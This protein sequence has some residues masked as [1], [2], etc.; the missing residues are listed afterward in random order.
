MQ[1]PQTV[2]LTDLVSKKG[3]VLLSWGTCLQCSCSRSCCVQACKHLSYISSSVPGFELELGRL[4]EDGGHTCT[5]RQ[6]LCNPGEQN[7]GILPRGHCAS[8]RFL[9]IC[10]QSSAVIC[11]RCFPK[12]S[13]A[14]I[15]R[16][17]SMVCPPLPEYLSAPWQD[18]VKGLGLGIIDLFFSITLTCATLV[19][20]TSHLCIDLSRISA[21]CHKILATKICSVT[22]LEVLVSAS[23]L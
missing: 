15:P 6:L 22:A 12:K 11:V 3:C 19:I 10:E 16:K 9:N 23:A 21:T 17:V 14:C 13:Q 18:S 20:Q 1:Q 7:T 8:L 2:E 4:K 5:H